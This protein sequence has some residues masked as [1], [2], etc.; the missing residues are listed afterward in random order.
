M[1]TSEVG[2]LIRN[3]GGAAG[4]VI[5]AGLKLTPAGRLV[6]DLFP[7][8]GANGSLVSSS[9]TDS[10]YTTGNNDN[11]ANNVTVTPYVSG[12]DNDFNSLTQ[13]MDKEDDYENRFISPY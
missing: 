3:L 11:N 6:M 5:A 13:Q 4:D 2:D 9:T 7:S 1:S 8:L 12:S 10:S